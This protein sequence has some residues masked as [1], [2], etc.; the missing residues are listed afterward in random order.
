M[1]RPFIFFSACLQSKR[2]HIPSRDTHEKRSNI[3][4]KQPGQ[5]WLCGS[6]LTYRK[7]GEKNK[8][9]HQSDL[10][11]PTFRKRGLRERAFAHCTT[12]EYE[13]KGKPPSLGERRS[14]R[15]WLTRVW[16]LDDTRE[17]AQRFVDPDN[18]RHLRHLIYHVFSRSLWI[19]QC[20]IDLLF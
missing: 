17:T 18:S 14:P 6:L 16:Q 15:E 12:E 3:Q 20:E 5:F 11:R 4:Q 2:E 8:E 19:I 1:Y 13:P 10:N 7:K 9:L